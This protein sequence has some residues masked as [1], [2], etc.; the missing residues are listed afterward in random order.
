MPIVKSMFKERK[1][2]YN[3]CDDVQAYAGFVTNAPVFPMTGKHRSNQ[4]A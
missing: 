1:P 4:L 2:L 3:F